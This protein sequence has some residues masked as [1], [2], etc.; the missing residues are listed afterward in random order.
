M[1]KSFRLQFTK[2]QFVVVFNLSRLHKAHLLHYWRLVGIPM[3]GQQ[4]KYAHEGT[5]ANCHL[6]NQPFWNLYELKDTGD[7]E[8]ALFAA[9]T[10]KHQTKADRVIEGIGTVIKLWDALLSTALYVCFVCAAPVLGARYQRREAQKMVQT[11]TSNNANATAV[12]PMAVVLAGVGRVKIPESE[13]LLQNAR[14]TASSGQ[15]A[16]DG[17]CRRSARVTR[18][19]ATLLD[20]VNACVAPILPLRNVAYERKAGTAEMWAIG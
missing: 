19:S 20:A 6:C 11:R 7:E 1:L 9:A 18:Q 10:R 4:V 2:D 13:T 8:K 15:I 3:I 5:V 16:S 12:L 17:T 14:S